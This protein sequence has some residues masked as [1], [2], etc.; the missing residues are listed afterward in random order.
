MDLIVQ[1]WDCRL[2]SRNA[3]H[4]H[5][6]WC[7]F[8]GFVWYFDT[9]CLHEWFARVKCCKNFNSVKAYFLGRAD[10]I[11]VSIWWVNVKRRGC[12]STHIDCSGYVAKFIYNGNNKHERPFVRYILAL[13]LC[14]L[15]IGCCWSCYWISFRFGKI[16]QKAFS[17]RRLLDDRVGIVLLDRYVSQVWDFK[18]WW[19]LH[20]AILKPK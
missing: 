18:W 12:N 16:F 17:R 8:K 11:Y 2:W 7:T 5:K 20:G 9:T 3:L 14:I 19:H 6:A 1:V 13:Q 10:V 15:C 4:L